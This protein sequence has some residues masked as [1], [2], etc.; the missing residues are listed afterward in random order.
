MLG[1]TLIQTGSRIIG[2]LVALAGII[3]LILSPFI[4]KALFATL[5]GV[6]P[7]A[8]IGAVLVI[9]GLAVISLSYFTPEVTGK[10]GRLGSTEERTPQKW[11][12]MTQQYFEL[13]APTWSAV[14]PK[15]ELL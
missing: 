13:F 15:V 3:S 9:G 4:G 12:Q 8:Y 6:E 1:S 11:S 14:K 10:K 2:A 5:W 7:L